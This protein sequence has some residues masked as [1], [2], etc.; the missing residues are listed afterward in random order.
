[1]ADG[2]RII[3]ISTR[4]TNKGNQTQRDLEKLWEQFFSGN[5]SD[6]ILNKISTEILAI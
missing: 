1:M 3:G 6:K 2:F 5:S 4:T